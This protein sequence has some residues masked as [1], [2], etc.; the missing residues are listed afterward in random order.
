MSFHMAIHMKSQKGN[1]IVYEQMS[2]FISNGVKKQFETGDNP[3]LHFQTI[4]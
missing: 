1:P 4:V 2:L 3:L